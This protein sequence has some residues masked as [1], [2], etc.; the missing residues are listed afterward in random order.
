LV[1]APRSMEEQQ[2]SGTWAVVRY[3]RIRK[4]TTV[5]LNPEADGTTAQIHQRQPSELGSG[6]VSCLKIYV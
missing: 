1:A 4:M 3:A 2:G 6:D 5:V